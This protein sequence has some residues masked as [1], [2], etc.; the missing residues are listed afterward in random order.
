[1]EEADAALAASKQEL[2]TAQSKLYDSSATPELSKQEQEA[3]EKVKLLES[4]INQ[5]RQAEGPS[6]TTALSGEQS[7]LFDASTGRRMIYRSVPEIISVEEN[8]EVYFLVRILADSHFNFQL[9]RNSATG[10][11][12]TYVG[13]EKGTINARS[14]YRLLTLSTSMWIMQPSH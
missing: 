4:Q 6:K 1:M 14:P 9:T 12:A 11:T 8:D 3:F 13:F 5:A 10:A 2:S 7:L